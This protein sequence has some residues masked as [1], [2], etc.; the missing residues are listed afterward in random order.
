MSL[1]DHVVATE[2][3]AIQVLG[4]VKSGV[5]V[6]SSQMA[7]VSAWCD[8][9]GCNLADALKVLV[10]GPAAT[11]VQAD[12]AAA[13]VAL[14]QAGSKALSAPERYVATKKAEIAVAT[15]ALAV[16]G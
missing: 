14:G 9:E 1:L 7:T 5:S 13:Q 10:P 11:A 15:L 3:D 2:A 8:W 12:L 4:A 16:L 6:T